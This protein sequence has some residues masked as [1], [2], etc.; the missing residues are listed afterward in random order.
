[1][2]KLSSRVFKWCLTAGTAKL[3]G[4]IH[5]AGVFDTGC[6]LGVSYSASKAFQ[7]F[8][9]QACLLLQV[10]SALCASYIGGSVNFAA[11]SQ[12]LGLTPGPL[13]AATMAADNIAMAVYL[14]VIMII[15]AKNVVSERPQP[16]TAQQLT[17]VHEQLH[18]QTADPP[19][20]ALASLAGTGH[21]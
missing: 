8:S 4:A 3:P 6:Q 14:T 19:E 9:T 2:L 1:M 7:G 11:V 15:P 17:A 21:M 20:T 18:A 12:S 5:V 16:I 10:A 13:L